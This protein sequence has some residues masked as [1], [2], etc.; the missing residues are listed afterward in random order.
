MALTA[1]A[2]AGFSGSLLQ[3]NFD[4]AVETP[5]CHMDWWG[6]C[7]GKDRYV[8]IAAPRRHAKTTAITTT[9][10][11]AC[12]LFRE[13]SYALIVSDTVTQAV[14]FLGDIK[15]ELANNDQLRALFK[16]KDFA[17]DSDD[18]FICVCEDGY[19]FR[20]QAKGSEQK[21]RGLK[22]NNKRPDLIVCDDL[23]NDEIVMNKDRRE[24]FRNWF[25]GALLPCISYN[26]IVRYVGT[27]LHND[28]LLERL[29]P[30]LYSKWTKVGPLVTFSDQKSSWRSVKYRAHNEDMSIFLWEAAAVKAARQEGLTTARE[31]FKFL[32]EGFIEQGLAEKY[33]Q[34]Y[35]NLPIDEQH[36]L[37]KRKNF[38]EMRPE[39]EDKSVHYYITADLAISESE[40]ADYSVF[41]VS[42]VDEHKKIYIRDVIRQRMDG[43]EIVDTILALERAWHPEVIGIE[44]M[45]VS[46]A[47]GPFL[48][49]EMA[50]QNTYPN[51]VQLKHQGKDKHARAKSIQARTAAHSVKFDKGGDWYQDFEDEVC[52]FPRAKHDDQFDAFAYLGMLLDVV[53]ESPS[54]EEIEE[55]I[56]ADE[57]RE[58]EYAFDGRS[59]FTG[60]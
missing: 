46:K 9:Y 32:R 2:I 27:I 1:D 11:L 22:W 57:L 44:E 19:E 20:V 41:I 48:R 34:E 23:E 49:E 21:V 3:K 60:Y 55:E 4:G 59:D 12:L 30:K 38:I 7:T 29:M 18:D 5:A 31:Y 37:L 24:K 6:L 39:D 17:K 36:T 42:A 43:K 8:A 25:F 26:G 40:R 33:S 35:L 50:R 45:Q 56:Y 52:T 54:K 16:I 51:L 13:R 10:T 58:S 53:I 14:Q 47:I 15:R 28:S